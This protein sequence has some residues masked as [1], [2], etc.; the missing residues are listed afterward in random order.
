[1]QTLNGRHFSLNCQNWAYNN[2][3]E[4]FWSLVSN[5]ANLALIQ[6]FYKILFPNDWTYIKFWYKQ[7][8]NDHHF[9]FSYRNWAC[10]ILLERSWSL[11]TNATNIAVMWFSYQKFWP[12]DQIS[13]QN[14][15]LGLFSDFKKLFSLLKLLFFC[16]N[17]IIINISL[18][19]II[20]DFIIKNRFKDILVIF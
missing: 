3:L 6:F 15:W 1:M 8:L 10:N 18:V 13:T 9:S 11:G 19:I 17:L 2:S 16:F 12:K 4:S 7:I 5:A 14:M 20:V